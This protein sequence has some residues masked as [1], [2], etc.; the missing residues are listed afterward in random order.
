[1][2]GWSSAMQAEKSPAQVVTTERLVDLG[3]PAAKNSSPSK[4]E[5]I[6]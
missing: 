1:M 3:T 2:L 4:V 6:A 5:Q